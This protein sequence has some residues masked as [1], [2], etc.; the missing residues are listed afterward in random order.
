MPELSRVRPESDAA[1]T[2]N[3]LWVLVGLAV[4]MSATTFV[5][6][7]QTGRRQLPPPPLPPRDALLTEAVSSGELEVLLQNVSAQARD[8]HLAFPTELPHTPPVVEPVLGPDGAP[9]P[10]APVPGPLPVL[11]ASPA[12]ATSA[13]VVTSGGTDPVGVAPTDG[14]AVQVAVTAKGL[15]QPLVS[16]L[17]AKGVTAYALDA[18]VDGQAEQRVRIG[19]FASEEAAQAAV[20][21]LRA[22]TGTAEVVKAP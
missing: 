22:L 20:P 8:A 6:G 11:V 13:V 14:Y 7:I 3:R 9:L 16:D 21:E 4:F 5:L 12:P 10:D 18:L 15:A 1:L 19:G 2:R 17:A